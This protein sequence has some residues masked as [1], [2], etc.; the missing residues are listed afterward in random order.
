M[1]VLEM[2]G[3]VAKWLTSD[4]LGVLEAVR[5]V[6]EASL[7][8]LVVWK[9]ITTVRWTPSKLAP[10]TSRAIKMNPKIA[11]VLGPLFVA[12]DV[13]LSPINVLRGFYRIHNDEPTNEEC[14]E[15]LYNLADQQEQ[16]SVEMDNSFKGIT[17]QLEEILSQ[18][19]RN[20]KAHK[21]WNSN[22]TTRINN[23]HERIDALSNIA[24]ESRTKSTEALERA[25]EI[26]KLTRK[27]DPLVKDLTSNMRE[28]VE[29]NEQVVVDYFKKNEQYKKDIKASVDQLASSLANHKLEIAD[30][31]YVSKNM[32]N[33]FEVVYNEIKSKLDTAVE[34]ILEFDE[35]SEDFLTDDD[36][37]RKEDPYDFNDLIVDEDILADFEEI[38]LLPDVPELQPT[39]ESLPRDFNLRT[40]WN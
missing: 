15:D 13:I 11:L 2:L 8:A 30:L 37:I 17:K 14:I 22:I 20:T 7:I 16:K 38:D 1:E 4:K 36:L 31:L 12:L 5:T 3:V 40:D 18:Q 6:I 24:V 33:Q 26:F 29:S 9:T 27:I 25:D 21:R 19:D 23:T 32:Q 10:V 39:A 34:P 35:D 28:L